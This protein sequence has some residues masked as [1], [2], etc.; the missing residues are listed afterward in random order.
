LE[1]RL[2]GDKSSRKIYRLINGSNGMLTL[3]SP[4]MVTVFKKRLSV[5]TR[6][7]TQKKSLSDRILEAI[8][9]NPI[10]KMLG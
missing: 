7:T 9:D 4:F 2:A 1:H 6:K 3:I 10:M 8:L 5:L